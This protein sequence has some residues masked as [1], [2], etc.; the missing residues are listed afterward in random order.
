MKK[1]LAIIPL[2]LALAAGAP[3]AQADTAAAMAAMY[4]VW[5]EQRAEQGDPAAQ[6]QLLQILR[7]EN[8]RMRFD[9]LRQEREDELRQREYERER[10]E[11]IKRWEQGR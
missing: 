5:I 10:M 7:A 11:I 3:P 8:A 4:R 2:A 1:L 9:E 6:A